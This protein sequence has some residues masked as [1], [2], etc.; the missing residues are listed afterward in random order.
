MQKLRNCWCGNEALEPYYSDYF[1]CS[2]CES[3]VLATR[4][5][6]SETIV[7]NDETDFY[8][9]QY[10]QSYVTNRGY[11]TIQERARLDLPERC[12]HWLK[13]IL[14]YKLPPANVLELGSAHGG[15]VAL[16]KWSGYNAVG[17]EMSPWLANYSSGIFD[18]KV[19]C[20]PVENQ[21]LDKGSLDII[22][23]F[24]VLEHFPDPT[25]TM[26]HCLS[27]LKDDG[28]LVIQTPSYP[29][30]KS[31]EELAGSNHSFLIQLKPEEHI[32]LFSE[33]SVRMF[34]NRLGVSNINFEPAIFAHYDMY[35]VASRASFRISDYSEVT[36]ALLARPSGRLI[37]ALLDLTRK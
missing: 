4:L 32:Y 37:Q 3:L 22:A 6:S 17:L 2:V 15:F 9:K 10:F 24:D 20:G 30:G 23:L 35:F 29:A 21:Q 25:E 12:L 36:E 13:T 14:K 7:R 34:F 11:P 28:V 18:V 26:K 5:E 1:R 8:G 31:Y 16:L 33:L 19:L 27:L